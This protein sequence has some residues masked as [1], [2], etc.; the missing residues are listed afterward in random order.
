LGWETADQWEKRD[1]GLRQPEVTCFERGNRCPGGNSIVGSRGRKTAE[2]RGRKVQSPIFG[3]GVP[4]IWPIYG[5]DMVL[6]WHQSNWGS[7][8]NIK[9]VNPK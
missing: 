9:G 6:I 5:F 4:H 8:A 7:G 3:M 1:R 2:K